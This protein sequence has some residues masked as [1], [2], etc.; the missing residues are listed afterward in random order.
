MAAGKEFLAGP[1]AA[2]PCKQEISPGKFSRNNRLQGKAGI[3]EFFGS[4]LS[5]LLAAF[6]GQFRRIVGVV[7]QGKRRAE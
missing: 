7:M 4:T 1:K 2:W 6:P 3:P 5:A